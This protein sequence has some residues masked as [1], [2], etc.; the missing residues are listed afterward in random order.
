VAECRILV[1][2]PVDASRQALGDRLQSLGYAVTL[3]ADGVEAAHAALGDPPGAVVADLAMPSISGVQLCRLLQAEPAT[4]H[5]PV[6]LRGVDG[7]LNRFWAEQAGATA[8]VVKGRTGDLVRALRKGLADRPPDDDFF[9]AMPTDGDIRDRIALH[10]DRALFEM[11]IASEVRKLGTCESFPHLF[12]LFAQFVAQVTAYRWL[13]LLPEGDRRAGLH[14]NPAT[15]ADA[16]SAARAA[17]G[18]GT[19]TSWTVIEDDDADPGPVDS[20]I[21]ATVALGE[22]TVG[23]VAMAPCGEVGEAHELLRIFARELGGPLRMAILVEESQRLATTD[24]LTGRMNRRAFCEAAEREIHR[25]HRHADPLSIAL[26]DLD[27]FKAINDHRGHATGDQVLTALGG[28]LGRHPRRSDLA[29]RWGGEEFV[30]A[31]PGTTLDRAVTAADRLRTAIASLELADAAGV[32]VRVTASIGVAQLAPGEDLDALVERADQAMYQAK[33]VGRN[34]VCAAAM[35]VPE[36]APEAVPEEP[37][38][39]LVHLG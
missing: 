24:P 9:Q 31:M 23:R 4:M 6:V 30:L 12:D 33:S 28:L 3:A 14:A 10:L 17:F 35:P 8:Y 34:R 27:H 36:P 18:V 29:A 16:E 11:V 37:A 19:D 20:V 26:L 38:P 22:R 32:A 15:R 5:V 7:R 21:T 25:S 2:D 13:A 1:V 39:A